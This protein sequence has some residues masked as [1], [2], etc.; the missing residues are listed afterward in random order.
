MASPSISRSFG[1]V[2]VIEPHI[3]ATPECHDALG[4]ELGCLVLR[5][6]PYIA[7]NDAGMPLLPDLLAQPLHLPP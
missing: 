6:S 5:R 7:V 3:L 1:E 4:D 2:L